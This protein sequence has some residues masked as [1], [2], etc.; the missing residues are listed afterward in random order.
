M[1]PR[2]SIAGLIAIFF[3]GLAALAAE[4]GAELFQKAK[5]QETAA[6][7]LEEAI[8]LYQKVAKDFA[9]DRPLAA[10]ALMAAAHCYELLGKDKQA[11]AV[12][13]YEQVARDFG[14]QRQPV[15][16][17][18][19]KL[20]SLR[21][22]DSAARPA[23]MTQRTT[24]IWCT[25]ACLPDQR[26]IPSLQLFHLTTTSAAAS[27]WFRWRMERLARCCGVRAAW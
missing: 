21:Q 6:G 8:K 10:K 17:A 11:N 9:S 12:K 25:R 7:N 1:K 5:T 4:S 26:S 19:A 2:I 24:A 13:L 18:R 16:A 22:G 20:A 14:D 27:L 3:C 23:T 15:E